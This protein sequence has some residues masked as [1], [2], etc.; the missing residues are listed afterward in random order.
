M[1]SAELLITALTEEHTHSNT[2]VS[3]RQSHRLEFFD[4]VLLF[5]SAVFLTISTVLTE[6]EAG[7]HTAAKSDVGHHQPVFSQK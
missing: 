5:T 1:M 3:P 2:V 4:P 6:A 7:L